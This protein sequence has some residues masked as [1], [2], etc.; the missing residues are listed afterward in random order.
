MSWLSLVM[1]QHQWLLAQLIGDDRWMAFTQ[2]VNRRLRASLQARTEG[3]AL[4]YACFLRYQ[5]DMDREA[6]EQRMIE[7]EVR[8]RW[9]SAHGPLG[10]DSSPEPD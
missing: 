5:N 9:Q 2:A 6:Y 10:W 8:L 1:D 7:E 4:D 3:L